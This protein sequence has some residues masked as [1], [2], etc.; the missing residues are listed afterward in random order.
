MCSRLERRNHLP[1]ERATG[2]WRGFPRSPQT[3]DSH[4]RLGIADLN[5]LRWKSRQCSH[6][7]GFGDAKDAVIT[8][9]PRAKTGTLPSVPAQTLREAPGPGR[10]GLGPWARW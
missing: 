10:D 5:T 1:T 2:R 4:R 9:P 7:L 6:I 8:S 3:P